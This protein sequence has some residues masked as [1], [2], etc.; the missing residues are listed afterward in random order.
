VSE[1]DLM[2][3]K[4]AVFRSAL[5]PLE[6]LVA[7]AL[8]D[9]WSRASSEPFPSVNRLAEWTS[10]D[11]RT[12]LRTLATLESK[13]AVRVTRKTGVSNAYSL[14]NL[15]RLPVAER[16]QCQ[17]VTSDTETPPPV[18][19]SHGDQCQAATLS[20]QLSNPLKEATSPAARK[21]RPRGSRG[22]A[23]EQPSADSHL[24][25]V[26]YA[27]EYKKRRGN[28]DEPDFGDRW[29]RAM[30]AFG[31]L[32]RLKGGLV[33]AKAIVSNALAN[34][35]CQRINPW[36][37]VDD[38]NKHRQPPKTAGRVVVQ[39]GGTDESKAQTWGKEGARALGI[40]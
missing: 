3:A 37:L 21:A 9:H 26:H 33:A 6:K 17:A 7:L 15:E 38:A 24:L 32:C 25:K 2:G 31:K 10:L 16:H 4:R 40:D 12:V 1:F 11:R 29:S 20:K 18:A 22:K 8:L 34:E 19:E 30:Q 35:Y 27:D 36:E 39:R 23:P 5:K 28:G 13:G 14:G